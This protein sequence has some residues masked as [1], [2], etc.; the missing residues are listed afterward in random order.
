MNVW[1]YV[2]G[3]VDQKLLE[4]LLADLR[5]GASFKVLAAGGRDAARP[6]ARRKLLTAQ[7]PV[8]LVVDADTT[9]DQ[10][11]RTQLRDIEEY[12]AWGS[13]ATP[14][15]V[16]QFVPEMEAVFFDSP[17][18]LKRLIGEDVSEQATAAGKFAPKKVLA[19][20]AHDASASS[21]I[22]R[23]E[24]TELDALRKHP[25]VAE[26]RRF[27]ASQFSGKAPG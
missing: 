20:L 2:E 9:D 17:A 6:M 14:H 8:V 19:M 22:D 25:V 26:L 27:V 12:L 3:P 21:L 24:P 1:I 15:K 16:S 10:K 7:E 23:L 11:A 5:P 18:V 13:A 4:Q